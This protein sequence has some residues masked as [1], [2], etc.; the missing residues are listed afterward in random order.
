LLRRAADE[1]LWE[2]EDDRE[3]CTEA[4]SCSAV[5]EAIKKMYGRERVE[6]IW[7]GVFE[8]YLEWLGCDSSSTG[9]FNGKEWSGYDD[10]EIQAIRHCWLY[11]AADL[12]DEGFRVPDGWNKAD[13]DPT[14]ELRGAA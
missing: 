12:W 1:H 10:R 8:D 7:Q 5:W 13:D 11:F 2:G 4:Y 6:P 14:L 9:Q 3:Y